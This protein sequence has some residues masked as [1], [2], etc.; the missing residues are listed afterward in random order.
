VIA[1]GKRSRR[2]TLIRKEETKMNKTGKIIVVLSSVFCLVF[3]GSSAFSKAYSEEFP[4]ARVTL[5]PFLA[6]GA[7]SQPMGWKLFEASWLI[8]HRVTT[9][10]NATLGQI[11]GLV[12]DKTEGRV[13]LVV[14]S[15]VPNIGGED[16]A[17]PYSSIANIGPYTCDFN[18]G[19]MEIGVAP[20]AG[21]LSEDPT[22]YALT[23]YPSYSEFYGLPSAIDAAWLSDIYRHYGQPP[24]WTEK[25]EQSP[26]AMEVYESRRLMGAAVQLPDGTAA[27]R[28][29][30]FVIDS[31]DGHIA[32]L[33]LSDVSGRSTS[34]VAVP[35]GIL[36]ARGG[37]VFVLDTTRDQLEFARDFDESNDLNDTR[38][39]GDVYRYFGQQPYWTERMEMAPASENPAGMG[40]KTDT[41][42]SYGEYGD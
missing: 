36:S 39:A 21:Y 29:N 26:M 7:S 18:P 31:S 17:I 32:F 15:D 38:W 25:G 40:Q 28:V 37:D 8:G 11:S 3:L 14:L 20:G 12:I 41:L 27:G 13:A 16:L 4:Q 35:F 24:Y 33:V 9:T 10:T 22:V 42:E 30:D 34:L 1:C 19:S 23:H 5:Q 6:A 2:L